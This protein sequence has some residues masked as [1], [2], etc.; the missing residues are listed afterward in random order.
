M[1]LCF[2]KIWLSIPIMMYVLTAIC[3]NSTNEQKR[4]VYLLYYKD[5]YSVA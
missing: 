3:W 5:D 1:L 2:L 4:R